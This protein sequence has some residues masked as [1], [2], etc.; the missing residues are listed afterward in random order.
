MEDSDG[1]EAQSPLP[2]VTP[3]PSTT[4]SDD[5][6]VEKHLPT[7]IILGSKTAVINFV[8]E[9]ENLIL[10][11]TSNLEGSSGNRLVEEVTAC[12]S[13]TLSIPCLRLPKGSTAPK[14]ALIALRSADQV[15][16]LAASAR[17]HGFLPHVVRNGAQALSRY[18]DSVYHVVVVDAYFPM[19]NGLEVIRCIRK[20]ENRLEFYAR[21]KAAK[22]SFI[23]VVRNGYPIDNFTDK[24]LLVG[25]DLCVEGH[26]D[27]R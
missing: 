16:Q 4:G 24:A 27:I 5:M 2:P 20:Y 13:P 19:L 8:K 9:M 6:D 21:S 25:A 3:P 7:K 11:V 17:L 12:E 22:G 23:V 26:N 18:S 1:D 10:T 15:I 14:T